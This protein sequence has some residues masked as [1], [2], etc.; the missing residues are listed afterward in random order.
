LESLPWTT[1]IVSVIGLVTAGLVARATNAKYSSEGA[2]AITSAAVKL[3]EPLQQRLALQD[4]EN[5]I[6]KD[7]IEALEAEARELETMRFQNEHLRERVKYLELQVE[8]MKES[9]KY[10]VN[11]AERIAALHLELSRTQLTVEALA[12]QVIELG[13]WPIN[14]PDLQ[15]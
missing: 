7:R 5:L 12:E 4:E 2:D 15:E 9:S 6:L 13:G 1:I 10:D 8:V 14:K 11:V 3:V